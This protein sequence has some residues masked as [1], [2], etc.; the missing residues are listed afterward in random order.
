MADNRL[1][2]HTPYHG[3]TAENLATLK[4]LMALPLITL[5]LAINK[6]GAADA[7]I[8][9]EALKTTTRLT[10]LGLGN[11]DLGGDS[12]LL[13]ITKSLAINKT[14]T[15]I[16]LGFYEDCRFKAPGVVFFHERS[17]IPFF[18]MLAGQAYLED[19][20]I[21]GF[22]NDRTITT[23]S[24]MLQMNTTLTSLKINQTGKYTDISREGAAA[25]AEGIKKNNTL[26]ILILENVIFDGEGLKLLADA[27]E[28]NS[29]LTHF[30]ITRIDN[31]SWDKFSL[32]TQFTAEEMSNINWNK[33]RIDR[34]IEV[35][36]NLKERQSSQSIRLSNLP[37]E[38]IRNE[39]Q[40][41]H[42]DTQSLETS[43][44]N[45]N[46]Q[47]SSSSSSSSSYSS[48]YMS[49]S[50][51]EEKRPPA[52]EII[53]C[54]MTSMERLPQERVSIFN[55]KKSMTL[56]AS[57][58]CV[59]LKPAHPQV[60]LQD[61]L[62]II[63]Q[64]QDPNLVQFLSRMYAELEEV[65][66]KNIAQ[67][68]EVKKLMIFL[69]KDPTAE[70][71]KRRISENRQLQEY[72]IKLC[73]LKNYFK[74]GEVLSTLLVAT[75]VDFDDMAAK[76]AAHAFKSVLDFIPVVSGL[77][78]IIDSAEAAHQMEHYVHKIHRANRIKHF[79]SGLGIGAEERLVKCFARR[80]TLMKE[81]QILNSNISTQ[82][83][84]HNNLLMKLS[85]KGKSL[86]KGGL[87]QY[88]GYLEG[89][90]Y[91]SAQKLALWDMYNILEA[92]V[93]GQIFPPVEGSEEELFEALM[94]S[95]VN[96]MEQEM[97]KETTLKSLI[98][99]TKVDRIT[100]S[101]GVMFPRLTFEDTSKQVLPKRG[102]RISVS[103]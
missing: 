82:S 91:S 71:Q 9:A 101:A 60:C 62:K 47:S 97:Q 32:E 68:R 20:V 67:D 89:V 42:V 56:F 92:I 59:E 100:N 33:A 55:R 45:G 88:M 65:R 66:A 94:G 8:I 19:V 4:A 61:M 86:V 84:I 87:E 98:P 74:A 10:N 73:E 1:N 29:S 18:K 37:I 49:R 69:D 27:L 72:Y 75:E 23:I 51:D 5:G 93:K 30:K 96:H 21:G 38:E 26:Q 16:W 58:A 77:S 14:I 53:S 24:D 22:F 36:R 81:N 3:T 80:L 79:T 34:Y 17:L 78:C 41:S 40:G 31:C 95:M 6:L 90:S 2:L 64:T 46:T 70:I 85:N 83:Q 54:E 44:L 63:M 12:G 57:P 103:I 52:S 39:P 102:L 43:Y 7:R 76:A 48:P 35:N 13:Q 50:Y 15:H 11:N 25:L 99:V 28:E